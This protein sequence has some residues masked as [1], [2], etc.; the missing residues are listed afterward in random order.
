MP[1]PRRILL[2][3]VVCLGLG[4]LVSAPIARATPI[5]LQVTGTVSGIVEEGLGQISSVSGGDPFEMLFTIDDGTPDSEPSTST[6]LFLDPGGRYDLTIGSYSIGGD[7]TSVTVFSSG[8]TLDAGDRP[9]PDP[10]PNTTLDGLEFWY[11]DVFWFGSSTDPNV[12]PDLGALPSTPTQIDVQF[13]E[14]VT[15]SPTSVS[16]SCGSAA[17]L[18]IT[19]SVSV[20]PE[21][22]TGHLFVLALGLALALE[23]L[24]RAPVDRPPHPPSCVS[25]DAIRFRGGRRP[26]PGRRGTRSGAWIAGR[27]G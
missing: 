17:T 6:G 9:G 14:S 27:R 23:G 18:S 25:S 8:T 12:F 5:T 21:P 24:R 20:V 1:H 2:E 4:V 26:A 19:A 22:T 7:Q 13:C 11:I 3:T 16:V 15:R 10:V